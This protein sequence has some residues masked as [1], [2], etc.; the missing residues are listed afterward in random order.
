MRHPSRAAR[1]AAAVL[2]AAAA[3][4]CGTSPGGGSG[5]EVPAP[6]ADPRVLVLRVEERQSNPYPWERVALP[7]F[8]LYGGGRVVVP[9]RGDGAL[10]AAREYRLP[11][12]RY[13]ALVAAAYDAGLDRS[14]LHD[15][16]SQT[17]ADATEV[18]LRTPDGLRV[19]KV[20]APDG[21]G[22]GARARVL[23]FLAG[24]PQPPR[25][26]A[27]YRPAA[28][29]VLATGGVDAG[30]RTPRP[31]PLRPPLAEGVRT[32][33]GQCRV[34]RGPAAAE[35]GRLAA[36]ARRDTRWSGGELTYAVAFRPLYPEEKRCADLD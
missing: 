34:L 22:D 24:L 17:D 32:R 35:A 20:V 28:L 8:A 18:A 16:R 15:D 2:I 26:T 4:G 6:P 21:G 14:A 27:P 33:D 19:T 3:A 31:W 13:R 7:R 1:V 11:K 10:F 25:D 5:T 36:G 29:A 30:T 23:D 9:G 12:A